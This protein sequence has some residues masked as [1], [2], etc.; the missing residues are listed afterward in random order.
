MGRGRG[1]HVACADVHPDPPAPGVHDRLL[2]PTPQPRA[3]ASRPSAVWYTRRS[4]AAPPGGACDR[5]A[6][7]RGVPHAGAGVAQLVEQ[8]I[9]N[10]QV[11][12]SS[13][14][15]GSRNPST[16]QRLSGTVRTRQTGATRRVCEW[17][18]KTRRRGLRPRQAVS[19]RR[20]AYDSSSS[21]G[22]PRSWHRECSDMDEPVKDDRSAVLLLVL[23]VCPCDG[24]SSSGARWSS[25]RWRR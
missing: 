12:S 20:V 5:A 19:P 18:A 21:V 16:T 15:A 6:G 4:R 9:R 10:R 13:L 17:C 22:R 23:L 14:A 2:R 8:P 25:T 3:V 11:A 1:R 7:C 24:T